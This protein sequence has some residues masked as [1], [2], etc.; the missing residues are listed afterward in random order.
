MIWYATPS[1]MCSTGLIFTAKL[2]I[3]RYLTIS[4][5]MTNRNG[6]DPME[7]HQSYP[8]C[9]MLAFQIRRARV[10]LSDILLRL[11]WLR[12]GF[13]RNEKRR[14]TMGWQRKKAAQLFRLFLNR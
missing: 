5:R 10:T 6:R 7:S 1:N 3:D 8:K 11:G 2:S 12:R 13:S 14:S 4:E 9:G